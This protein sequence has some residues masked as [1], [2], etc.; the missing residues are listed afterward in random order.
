MR[1]NQC[2][3]ELNQDERFCSNCGKESKSFYGDS[4]CALEKESLLKSNKLHILRFLIT[5]ALC[6][7]GS[8]LL[9]YV[10]ITKC[11]EIAKNLTYSPSFDMQLLSQPNYLSAV[12]QTYQKLSW[13]WVFVP[14]AIIAL[15]INVIAIA[16]KWWLQWANVI[17]LVLSCAF[18]ISSAFFGITYTTAVSYTDSATGDS[19]STIDGSVDDN[20]IIFFDPE[21]ETVYATDKDFK[22]NIK[23]GEVEIWDYIY[24]N[25]YTQKHNLVI[26]EEIEGYPV[27][28]ITNHA[29]SDYS[30]TGVII[31]ENVQ[32]IE[33]GAFGSCRFLK[34]IYISS[35]VS[36]IDI[37]AFP[38]ENLENITVSRDNMS[39]C[40]IDGVLY[41]KTQTILW[42][43]PAK[44]QH[45]Q[46]PTT[47]SEIV[48]FTDCDELDD[49]SIP[50]C[51]ITIGA[52]AF[53]SCD[54][55]TS[56][57]IPSS[58]AN[59]GKHAFANCDGLEEVIF[60]APV[61][62]ERCFQGCENLRSVVLSDNVT[63]I[64]SGAFMGCTSLKE[65]VIPNS[66]TSIS[67]WVFGDQVTIKCHKGSYADEFAKSNDMAVVYLTTD[68]TI[69]QGQDSITAEQAKK[70]AENLI[71]TYHQ[72]SFLGVCC[73]IE[74]SDA[75]M[76]NYLSQSQKESYWNQQYK[77]KCCHSVA[78]VR[79]HILE[80]VDATL[81][82][83]FSEDSLFTDDDGNLYVLVN[84]MGVAGY[85]E[86]NIIE[87]S[88]YRIVAEAPQ[89]DIDGYLGVSDI[90][91]IERAGS[92]YVIT[93]VTRK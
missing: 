18:A 78:D 47:V 74:Y 29:F 34:Y 89:Q 55:I 26:P 27:V 83:K 24:Q 36:E 4:A 80:T 60:N 79:E 62:S 77:L 75:D 31:P 30:L 70:I 20:P 11:L 42:G 66:V 85:G 76:T 32:A 35:S 44:K 93:K 86:I 87:H 28:R 81:A 17:A 54:G 7:V 73:D 25:R 57:T 82:A 53:Q 51:V 23:N 3:K 48:S 65:I 63:T 90:F 91:T 69:E 58:V 33:M 49:L 50:E 22:Y 88:E 59:L 5:C 9:I 56:I 13:L 45:L 71:A 10:P 84:P 40:S 67:Y 37:S 16:K 8:Y 41:S 72:Y 19:N 6:V 43:C 64:E 38:T 15:I 12:A 52:Y 14:L 39:F 92:R 68:E 46:I 1:C 2:G 61:I 21:Y